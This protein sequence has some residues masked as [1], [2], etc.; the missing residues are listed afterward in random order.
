MRVPSST[1]AGMLTESVRS[2][3]TRPEPAQD[4]HGLSITWPRP[5]QVGQ[6]RSS[7]KKP[8]AWR[9]RPAPP[10]VGQVFGLRAGLG[11]GAG[12]GLAGDRGR[13][14]HLRGL[15]GEGLLEADLHVVAQVGAALA[16]GAAAAPAAA[17]AEQIVEDVG[18]GRGEVGAEAAGAAGPAVLEGGM[19]EAVIG[20]ALLGVLQDLVGL[21]DLLEAV[22]AVLVAGI[23]VGMPLHGELAE[24]GLEL[25]RRLAV[26]ST[27]RTS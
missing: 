26:R 7:V 10:Q 5:W 18:E 20:G 15:A 11:A 27:P 24:R 23:A 14:A 6:V 1:P 8:W 17:H 25:R 19:A 2:R 22:L 3:V 4:G 12:A 13:N 9:M 21:V 16:A